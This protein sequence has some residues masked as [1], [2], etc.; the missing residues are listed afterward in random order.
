VQH[1]TTSD[2]PGW[3]SG[4]LSPGAAFTRTFNTPGTYAYHCNIHTFMHGT[5]IVSS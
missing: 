5:V 4:P 3:D 2:S 1:T